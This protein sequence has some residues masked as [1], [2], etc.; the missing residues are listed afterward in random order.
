M[1][2]TPK[3]LSRSNLR[4]KAK[5]GESSTLKEKYWSKSTFEAKGKQT[6]GK[7][8]VFNL[9]VLPSG[10]K[11]CLLLNNLGHMDRLYQRKEQLV[12]LEALFQGDQHW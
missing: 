7:K 6:F 8:Q 2:E 9:S 10:S 12:I 11:I 3:K 1:T 4:N 5:M